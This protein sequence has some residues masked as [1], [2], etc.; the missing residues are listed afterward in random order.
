[1]APYHPHTGR[2]EYATGRMITYTTPGKE[3]DFSAC[4]VDSLLHV[5]FVVPFVRSSALLLPVHSSAP[6]HVGGAH[7]RMTVDGKGSLMISFGPGAHDSGRADSA[8]PSTI[9]RGGVAPLNGQSF[10]H[11][12]DGPKGGGRLRHDGAT[13]EVGRYVVAPPWLLPVL[14]GSTVPAQR[15]C[16]GDGGRPSLDYPDLKFR[17]RCTGRVQLHLV[18]LRHFWLNE[19]LFWS[20]SAGHFHAFRLMTMQG[21]CIDLGR[22]RLCEVHS[23]VPFYSLTCQDARGSG[24]ARRHSFHMLALHPRVGS[25]FPVCPHWFVGAFMDEILDRVQSV[26]GGDPW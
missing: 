7:S 3:K 11:H 21:D 5:L 12:T 2:G 13:V 26:A 9:T 14:H 4:P 16:A 8:V 24:A 10:P 22:R 25:A 6:T 19:V 20:Y 17:M 18:R 1:M 23:G 15:L